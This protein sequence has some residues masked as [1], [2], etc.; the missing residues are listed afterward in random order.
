MLHP[1]AAVCPIMLVLSSSHCRSILPRDLIY[2]RTA[3]M[4]V[5]DGDFVDE[6]SLTYT[7]NV[8]IIRPRR[9]QFGEIS[10]FASLFYTI[11]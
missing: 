6:Q 9:R 10:L 11:S 7:K 5:L 8:H 1:S 2:R 3:V 4:A